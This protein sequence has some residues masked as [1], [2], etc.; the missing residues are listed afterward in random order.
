MSTNAA[1]AVDSDLPGFGYDCSTSP[2]PSPVLDMLSDFTF[3]S[4]ALE[5]HI[6]TKSEH[7]RHNT[8]MMMTVDEGAFHQGYA[9]YDST[10]STLDGWAGDLPSK[11]IS[12][13]P[14]D[15]IASFAMNPVT[16]GSQWPQGLYTT[17]QYP[18][19]FGAFDLD[20]SIGVA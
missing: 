2:A 8:M 1:G 12:R 18:S 10:F 15:F 11:D 17:Q 14:G 20:G 6:D 19:G 3:P 4:P 13:V 5:G 16:T 7:S 9:P